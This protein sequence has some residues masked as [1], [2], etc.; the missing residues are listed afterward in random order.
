MAQIE[1]S[2]ASPHAL[3]EL[4]VGSLLNGGGRPPFDGASPSIGRHSRQDA[5]PLVRSPSPSSTASMPST[6]TTTCWGWS[7]S[8]MAEKLD[9]LK[10]Q[11]RVLQ[12]ALAEA[13]SSKV[14]GGRLNFCI[15]HWVAPALRAVWHRHGT[16]AQ[17]SEKRVHAT[18][19]A[20][21]MKPQK[22]AK[23]PKKTGDMIV[24]VMQ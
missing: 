5:P 11:L 17:V 4:G 24:E 21:K 18:G 10:D 8:V 13:L 3:A 6:A 22:E 20:A 23:K 9:S 12:A 14:H 1:L 19:V 16:D 7:P 2:V 15:F